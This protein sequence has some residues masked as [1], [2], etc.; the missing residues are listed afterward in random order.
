MHKKSFSYSHGVQNYIMVPLLPTISTLSIVLL[1]HWYCK[2]FY[3]FKLRL[4]YFMYQCANVNFVNL[5]LMR[6]YIMS[7]LF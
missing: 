2:L 4:Y 1:I 3:Y 6:L 7:L 5:C